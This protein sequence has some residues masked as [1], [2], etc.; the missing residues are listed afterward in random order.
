MLRGNVHIGTS[1]WHYKHWVG[2]FYPPKL[3]ASKMLDHYVEHFDT[4]EINN[5]FYRLPLESALTNWRDSTPPGFCFALKGSRFLTHMKK[6]KDPAQGLER[7]FSRADLLGA[8]LGPVLWQLPPHWQVNV[9]R[10]EAFL[11]ALPRH[12][13][14]AFEFRNPTW[15]HP[16]VHDL[17]GRYDAAYCI[18][19]L[20]G[21]QSP[22]TVTSDFAYVRLHGPGGKYQGTYSDQAL[23]EWAARIGQWRKHL[24]AV[25][26]YFDNDQAAYAVIDAARLRGLTIC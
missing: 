6:L 7:F 3:P 22:L 18:F 12:H 21:Y 20:A 5:S 9:D 11:T 16:Q 1:G 2:P 26:V 17:L 14:A 24:R 13:R 4:V 23:A 15:D 10:L 19:D 8:K 25:Y